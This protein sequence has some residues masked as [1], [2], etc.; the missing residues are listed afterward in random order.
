MA[1]QPLPAIGRGHN[2]TYKGEKNPP[3]YF[4]PFIGRASGYNSILIT[5]GGKGPSCKWLIDVSMRS[6]QVVQ[7]LPRSCIGEGTFWRGM[8]GDPNDVTVH[9]C[10]R[11]KKKLNTFFLKDEK[12]SKESG[13]AHFGMCVFS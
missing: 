1:S 7:L 4:R 5:I 2:S 6:N 9:R 8:V 10:D 12:V 3:I 13:K 11:S